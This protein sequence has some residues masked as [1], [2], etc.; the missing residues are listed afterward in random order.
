MPRPISRFA[1]LSFVAALLFASAGV[2]TWSTSCSTVTPVIKDVGHIAADCSEPA[3]HDIATHILDDVTS[4]LVTTD[5][6]GGIL[7]IV[8]RVVSGVVSAELSRAEEHAWEA[9]KCSVEEIQK[10]VGTHLAYGH[11][12]ARTMQRETMVKAHAEQWL[13]AH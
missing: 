2:A 7:S 9:A 8:Q 1:S 10:Q 5:Y 13:S 6:S 4:A 11:M 12:D 3:V